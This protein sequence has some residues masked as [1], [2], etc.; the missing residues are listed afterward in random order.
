[1]FLLP[2][3][4]GLRASYIISRIKGI[5]TVPSSNF[6]SLNIAGKTRVAEDMKGVFAYW[7]A[8]S[9]VPVPVLPEELRLGHQSKVSAGKRDI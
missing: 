9:E 8:A 1:L 3:I 6:K 7:K 2:I 5:E 4:L